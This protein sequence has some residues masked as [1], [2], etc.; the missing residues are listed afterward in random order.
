MF[1]VSFLFFPFPVF[2]FLLFFP[3]PV[4]LSYVCLSSATDQP[5]FCSHKYLVQDE[6]DPIAIISGQDVGSH[7]ANTSSAAHTRRPFMFHIPVHMDKDFEEPTTDIYVREGKQ[8]YTVDKTT[9]NP[10]NLTT[11][12]GP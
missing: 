5:S 2:R 3:F 12:F 1:S 9:L 10:S 4:F 6:E 11:H 7:E 8:N